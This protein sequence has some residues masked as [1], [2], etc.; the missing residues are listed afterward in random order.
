VEKALGVLADG[1]AAAAIAYFTA[2]V[3][4]DGSAAAYQ[5][6]TAGT[7]ADAAQIDAALACCGVAAPSPRSTTPTPPRCAAPSPSSTRSAK[8]TAGSAGGRPT[9]SPGPRS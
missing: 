2:Q 8:V 4:A 3:R 1:D 5:G 6:A 9:T 7:A